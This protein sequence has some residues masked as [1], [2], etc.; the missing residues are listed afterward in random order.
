MAMTPTEALV[1]GALAGMVM[2]EIAAGNPS[3]IKFH[4]ILGEVAD[5]GEY[6]SVMTLHMGSGAQVRIIVAEV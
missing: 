1:T 4:S 3:G 2:R 5:D 6:K